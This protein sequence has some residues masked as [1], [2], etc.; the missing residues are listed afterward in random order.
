MGLIAIGLAA[1]RLGA[2]HGLSELHSYPVDHV[3]SAAKIGGA[4][5]L[6]TADANVEEQAAEQQQSE[7]VAY[8]RS[9]HLLFS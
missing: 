6:I 1:L 7:K 8:L 2:D 5:L 9:D 3:V 4:G